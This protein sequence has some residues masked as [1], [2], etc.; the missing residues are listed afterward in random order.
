MVL[1][2]VVCKPSSSKPP[3]TLLLEIRFPD[4]LH[5][6][7]LDLV[8][9]AVSQAL[10]QTC[11]TRSYF[12][13][14]SLVIRRHIIVWEAHCSRS[15]LVVPLGWLCWGSGGEMGYAIIMRNCHTPAQPRYWGG[16]DHG[17]VFARESVSS[18]H[19]AYVP[20]NKAYRKIG[21]FQCVVCW[22]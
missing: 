6:H 19:R 16:C 13:I 14:R 8:R 12:S 3:R 9:N 5:Q 20:G 22:C 2:N 7:Q 21:W 10:P 17:R 18:L 1:L 4:Q 15:F 11:W